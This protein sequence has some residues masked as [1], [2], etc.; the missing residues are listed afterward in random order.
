MRLRL[1]ISLNLLLLALPAAFG[2]TADD[3][4]H[5]GAQS[6]LS[7]NIP[8]AKEEVDGGLK[9]YP[10]DIKLKKLKEL[11]EQQSQQQSQKDQQK[12]EQQKQQQN[13]QNQQQQKQQQQQTQQNQ[14]K[15]QEQQAKNQSSEQ[16]EQQKQEQAKSSAAQQKEKGGEKEQ[17]QSAKPVAAHEMTPQEA[18]K[19]LDAQKG[20]EMVLQLKPE[21]KPERRERLFKD[22]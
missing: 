7:N 3:F 21:G 19:L 4:F 9:L 20:D 1:H 10:D 16:K 22:W 8:K 2:Q 11:L 12:Q 6:Y 5:G 18:K 17:A 14:Q 13:Q 15:Q